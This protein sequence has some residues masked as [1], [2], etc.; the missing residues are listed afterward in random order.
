MVP[1]FEKGFD[2]NMPIS[3]DGKADV[4]GAEILSGIIAEP[5]E[6][7]MR[8]KARTDEI[9]DGIVDGARSL[10]MK[11][12]LASVVERHGSTLERMHRSTF[13]RLEVRVE[14]AP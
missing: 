4:G 13:T 14:T 3:G 7:T 12:R 5:D 11:T 10:E 8:D 9:L 2:S 6:T 1:K